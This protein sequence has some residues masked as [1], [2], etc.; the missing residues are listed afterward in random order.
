M[1]TKYEN[2]TLEQRLGRISK[3]KTEPE[4]DRRHWD[5]GGQRVGAVEDQEADKEDED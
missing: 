3:D 1:C 4:D 5:E 2:Q